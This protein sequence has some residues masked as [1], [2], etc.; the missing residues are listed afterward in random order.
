[1]TATT[2]AKVNFYETAVSIYCAAAK[3]LHI[4]L[5]M[6]LIVAHSNARGQFTIVTNDG[7]EAA[8][9][10]EFFAGTNVSIWNLDK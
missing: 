1:V 7:R 6:N 2:E 4:H 10:Q 3:Y 9:L 8:R 5:S